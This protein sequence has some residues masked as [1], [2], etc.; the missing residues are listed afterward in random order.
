MAGQPCTSPSD[1]PQGTCVLDRDA[2]A[3][4]VIGQRERTIAVRAMAEAARDRLGASLAVA[5][6]GV[7][8]PSGGSPEKPVGTVWF[9][10]AG[11]LGVEAERI[12]FP[13]SRHEIQARAGQHAL[14]GLLRRVRG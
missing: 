14:F 2:S 1:C 3:R 11:P 6:S 9:G 10:F 13:G 12:G 7:A 4:V 8:G 5:V